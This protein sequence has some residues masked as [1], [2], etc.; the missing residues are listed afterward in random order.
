MMCVLGF[1]KLN[2]ITTKQ[3]APRLPTLG[4]HTGW[5]IFV[6]TADCFVLL[7]VFNQECCPS[8]VLRRNGPN[9]PLK[10]KVDH[11]FESRHTIETN[12]HFRSN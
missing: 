6:S 2:N 10:K 11:I 1:F 3:P 12:I 9:S 4:L 8:F 7:S 5:F